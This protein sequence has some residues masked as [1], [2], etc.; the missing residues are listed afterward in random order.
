MERHKLG[1][2]S[3]VS[4]VQVLYR[5]RDQITSS[6]MTANK[7]K[8]G[9]ETLSSSNLAGRYFTKMM[10][11]VLHTIPWKHIRTVLCRNFTNIAFIQ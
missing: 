3:Q 1:E 8:Q 7:H 5:S 10:T 2:I 11:F 4:L 6:E 9:K